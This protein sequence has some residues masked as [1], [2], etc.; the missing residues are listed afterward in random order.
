MKRRKRHNP[1]ADY[2]R[3]RETEAIRHRI[4]DEQEYFKE[5]KRIF[6]NASVN[7]DKEI[8]AF[9]MRYA[10]KEGI[11][12][13]EAKKRASQM[14]IEAFSNKAKRYVKTKDFSDQANEELRLY[15]LTMKVN[16]LELLKA[17]IGLELVDAYQDLED[18]TRKAMTERTREE[19]KRQSGIL[20]ES[21]NDSKAAVEDIVGQSFYN[22]T[23]SDRIWHNQ[24]LLKSQLDTLIST[25]L[26]QGRNPK[27][28]A[29]ELQKVFGTSRY[30][31]ER[32]LITELARVQTQSQQNAYDQCGYDEYQF[33]T[34]GVG[35]CDI[36]RP[37]DGKIFKVRDM[38]VGENAPPLHPNC[39]CSTSAS[40]GP[41]DN[42]NYA[43]SFEDSINQDVHESMAVYSLEDAKRELLKSPVGIDT[44]NAIE[45][46]DVVIN[47]INTRMHPL[48]ARGEQAGDRIDIYARQCQNKLVFSQTIVHEMAHYRFAIGHCQHAEAIC[49]AMEKMHLERRDYLT[50]NEWER[51]KKLAIDNY[52]EYNWEKGGYGNYEQFDFVKK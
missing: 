39:R 22:A 25:G 6:D 15:N 46:S 10:K 12:L 49:F 13:A 50:L 41:E 47:I 51:M 16:R 1:S 31:A 27:A 11:T 36:C 40:I 52:P 8:K 3:E 34:I 23:F 30:N 5:V 44:F 2:W 43:K 4:K 17:N 26:I 45:N 24:T 48:R 14:D 35:A 28:L 18:I 38:L 33:I 20:G 29:G 42:I 9:Y 7:I 21:I 32:L 37:M 19:L